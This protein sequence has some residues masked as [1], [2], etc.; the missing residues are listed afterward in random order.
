[1]TVRWF[2]GTAITLE[3]LLVHLSW[4]F[5]KIFLITDGVSVLLN[6]LNRLA[7]KGSFLD[8]P[9]RGKSVVGG[10]GSGNG[11][12]NGGSD[13]SSISS[14]GIS[15]RGGQVK[16]GGG[17]RVR[18]PG[19]VNLGGRES[20]KGSEDDLEISLFTSLKTEFWRVNAKLR[21]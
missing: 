20:Q 5:E 13:G 10:N 4:I 8:F 2:S 1:M 16:P 3:A 17:I 6:L 15:V 19:V 21:K 7:D 12:S 11:S 18:K 14:T 9:G